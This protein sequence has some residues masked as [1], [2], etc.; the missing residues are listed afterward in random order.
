ME[1]FLQRLPSMKEARMR[2]TR[3]PAVA[4]LFAAGFAVL[5][6]A[7][8]ADAQLMVRGRILNIQ[9]QES[10][11]PLNLGVSNEVTPELDFSYY[12]TPNIAVELILATQRHNVTNSGVDV[13]SVKHLPPTL[14]LQ[15]HFTQN[16]VFKPYV[17]VGVNYTRFYDINLAGGTLTVDRNSWGGALQIGVD[18]KL[19]GN[20]YLNVDLKKIWIETDVKTTGG[21]FVSSLK[22]DPLV[23][24]LGLGYKF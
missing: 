20:W 3:S 19:S 6:V 1:R 22:I 7:P 5:L 24:G 14:T 18:Y 11:S 2:L 9:P 10:S 23:F 12:F 15:Y 21:A 13:G 17:G 16:P 4:A 8:S